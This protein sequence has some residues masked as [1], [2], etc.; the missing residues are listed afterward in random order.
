MHRFTHAFAVPGAPSIIDIVHPDT[1]LSTWGGRTLEEVQ[2]QY[3]GA[4]LVDFEEWIN[5]TAAAQDAEPLTWLPSTRDR[6]WAALGVLPPAAMIGSWF[7]VGEPM[8]HHARGAPRFS[9]Y[10]SVGP[11]RYEQASR[12]ITEEEFQKAYDER[13]E[14]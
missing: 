9:S 4:E 8:D 1:G 6:Y 5:A 7:L 10:R 12:P 2:A 14:S 13:G 11:G 3:P